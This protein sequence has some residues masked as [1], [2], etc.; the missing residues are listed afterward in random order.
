MAEVGPREDLAEAI[1]QGM[2]DPRSSYD[3]GTVQECE[4]VDGIVREVQKHV[5]III[6]AVYH[7]MQ[8]TDDLDPASYL[9]ELADRLGLDR[10]HL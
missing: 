6:R 10:L 2:Y 9:E 1:W 4:Y 8:L 7:D 3:R 5:E